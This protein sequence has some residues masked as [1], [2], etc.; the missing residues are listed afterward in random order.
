[1]GLS[2]LYNKEMDITVVV[3]CYN[4]RDY[5][6]ETL[7]NVIGALLESGCS[8]EV[9][10]IDDV[11]Q[12]DSVERINEYIKA[13]QDYPILLKVNKKNRGLANNFI[14]GAFLGQGKYYR[15]C[16][17]DNAET[18]ES[19][20]YLF[21]HLG[22]ADM[23]IPYQKQEEVFGKS[24]FRK[25][26]SQTFTALVNII[27]GYNIKYY[28]SLPVYLRYHVM[29]WAPISCGFGFQADMITRILDE[30]ITY[31]QI[32]NKGTIHRKG[33]NSAAL[34]MRNILSV[35]HTLLEISIRRLKKMIYGKNLEKP[36]EVTQPPAL[37][38]VV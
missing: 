7:N 13:H 32:P 23:V 17:G 37:P 11:S 25:F 18:R 33:R 27:S 22:V 38:E 10:V 8:Y 21:K 35:I 9:I 4:E 20:A 12:D 34:T 26:L 1:M 15:L 14:D 19:L 2:F 36:V 24:H 5:I 3:T 30:G 29:R 28:N 16:C 31:I 6:K